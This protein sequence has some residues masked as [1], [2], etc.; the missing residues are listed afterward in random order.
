MAN[1]Y[2]LPAWNKNY[3]KMFFEKLEIVFDVNEISD[4]KKRCSLCVTAL[5]AA[6]IG[7]T[8]DKE[9]VATLMKIDCYEAL[10]EAILQ[11][12]KKSALE[13]MELALTL[14]KLDGTKSASFWLDELDLLLDDL[15]FDD[16]RWCLFVRNMPPCFMFQM[17]SRELKRVKK[18]LRERQQ[19]LC[20]FALSLDKYFDENGRVLDMKI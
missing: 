9:Q 10:K 2:E 7:S 14:P 1:Q 12:Y 8:E 4:T 6:D 11:K 17:G 5:R 19:P 15:T 20:M 13:R 16:L 18:S 3:P